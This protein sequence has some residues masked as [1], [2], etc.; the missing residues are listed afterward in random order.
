MHAWRNDWFWGLPGAKFVILPRKI[1]ISQHY[2]QKR[3]QVGGRKGAMLAATHSARHLS[4]RAGDAPCSAGVG[5]TRPAPDLSRAA[6]SVRASAASVGSFGMRRRHRSQTLPHSSVDTAAAIGDDR[7]TSSPVRRRRP[8]WGRDHFP[9]SGV[10][11]A[12]LTGFL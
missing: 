10:F 9:H 6:N 2:C 11:D 8:A 5:R 3:E 1:I 12:G 7:S 4:A